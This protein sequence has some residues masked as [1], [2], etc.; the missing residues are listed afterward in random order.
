MTNPR[1]L[2]DRELTLIQMYAYWELE[3][4][5][6]T[7]YSKW[8]VTYEQIA[9]ICSR[10][11]ATVRH[12][13]QT[14]KNYRSPTSGD[15]RHLALMDFLLEDFEKIPAEFFNQLYYRNLGSGRRR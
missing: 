13:F 6:R 3:L 5:P 9:L 14:G 7:F 15:K 12:W 8:E 10:S 4:E 1:P 2:G 11:P